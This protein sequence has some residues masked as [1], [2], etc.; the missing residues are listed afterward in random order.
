[1]DVLECTTVKSPSLIPNSVHG[2]VPAQGQDD[3]I[4]S[5]KWMSLGR[6]DR[7]HTGRLADVGGGAVRRPE[8]LGQVAHVK[9]LHAGHCLS[10]RADG[11][12]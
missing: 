6:G 1:M 8:D 2:R 12:E 7:V 5:V 4:G 10:D 9:K 3:D 11:V